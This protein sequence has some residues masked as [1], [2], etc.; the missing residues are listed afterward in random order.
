MNKVI[1]SGNAMNELVNIDNFFS[2]HFR[3]LVL[4]SPV[5]K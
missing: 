4:F 1:E 2:F 5:E 3:I